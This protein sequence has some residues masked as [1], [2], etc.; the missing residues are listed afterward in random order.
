MANLTAVIAAPANLRLKLPPSGRLRTQSAPQARPPSLEQRI[1]AE[2]RALLDTLEAHAQ[3][4]DQS[5]PTVGGCEAPLERLLAC[6][7][8]RLFWPSYAGYRLKEL[9]EGQIGGDA[10]LAALWLQA[11]GVMAAA[12]RLAYKHLEQEWF[13]ILA[14]PAAL[15]PAMF[16]RRWTSFVYDLSKNSFDLQVRGAADCL[17]ATM[18]RTPTYGKPLQ[19][20]EQPMTASERLLAINLPRLQGPDART[21]WGVPQARKVTIE[22]VLRPWTIAGK[23]NCAISRLDFTAGPPWYMSSTLYSGTYGKVRLAL[24]EGAARAVKELRR[25]PTH[26]PADASSLRPLTHP[27]PDIDAL[28]E[29]KLLRLLQGDT[30]PIAHAVSDKANYVAMPLMS[31]T[32]Q[33]FADWLQGRR[34]RPAPTERLQLLVAAAK[35]LSEQLHTFQGRFHSAMCDIKPL[36]VLVHP[37]WGCRL[38]DFGLDVPAEPHSEH[39]SGS[40]YGSFG[41][42]APE[43]YIVG[44]ASLNVDVWSLGTTLA[45]LILPYPSPLSRRGQNHTIAHERQSLERYTLWHRAL[46]RTAADRIDVAQLQPAANRFTLYFEKM[47]AISPR[48]CGDYLD[49][50]QHPDPQRRFTSA[51]FVQWARDWA[52]RLPNASELLQRGLQAYEAAQEGH[53]QLLG[54]LERVAAKATDAK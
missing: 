21:P 46:P 25:R 31:G 42:T 44:G 43:G 7:D 1:A 23:P 11:K 52:Q 34:L 13:D 28:H 38:I 22:E 9:H 3:A 15:T 41:Y 40:A 19:A 16:A 5:R 36:N 37:Q 14:R 53:H 50:I 32:L 45:D 39:I 24:I 33:G 10:T 18:A 48:L 2:V 54:E 26:V 12:D 35:P 30:M 20:C 8:K 49:F 29:V 6:A 27:T 47:R 17:I 4:A 51:A